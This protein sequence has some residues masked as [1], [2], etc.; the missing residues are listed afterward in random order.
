[1]HK[2]GAIP[3]NIRGKQIAILFITSQTHGRWVF[4]KG[5]LEK[6]ENHE[7]GVKREAYEEAG[8]K[9][10]VL[11]NFPITIPITKKTN[12]GLMKI[13]VTYYPLLVSE[14][15][16]EWPEREKRQRHWSLVSDATRLTDRIDFLNL[17]NQFD[18]LSP[19]ILEISKSKS[20]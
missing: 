20:K 19:W 12:D 4:P 9:G 1:M 3:F 11:N 17:I 13:P 14:Q 7:G 2:I 10:D 8:I 5:T 15:L 16:E 6:G 18:Q